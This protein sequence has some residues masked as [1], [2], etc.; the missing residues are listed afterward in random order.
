MRVQLPSPDALA[1][2]CSDVVRRACGKKKMASLAK[3]QESESTTGPISGKTSSIGVHNWPKH[4]Q[5][6]TIHAENDGECRGL[7]CIALQLG[8]S[9][10]ATAPSDCLHQHEKR[11]S[12]VNVDHAVCADSVLVRE[13]TQFDE[14]LIRVGPSCRAG[15]RTSMGRH[16]A[17]YRGAVRLLGY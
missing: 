11:R 7:T 5:W 16:R 2:P 14:Q 3:H 10:V 1:Q 9:L 12:L 17:P 6:S 8:L 15:M 13:P 4:L